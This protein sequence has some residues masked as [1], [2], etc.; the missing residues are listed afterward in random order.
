MTHDELQAVIDRVES[1][2]RKMSE[3]GLTSAEGM[4]MLAMLPAAAEEYR[5]KITLGLGAIPL[6]S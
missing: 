6:R 2:R 3:Q 5:R 1:E 4:K